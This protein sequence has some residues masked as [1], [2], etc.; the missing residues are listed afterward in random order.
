MTQH[1]SDYLFTTIYF[2]PSET[3]NSGF[4]EWLCQASQLTFDNYNEF[5]SY[6]KNWVMYIAQNPVVE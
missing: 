4:Q 2:T 6:R 5:S 1:S 3:R